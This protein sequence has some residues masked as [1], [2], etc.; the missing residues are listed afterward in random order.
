MTSHSVRASV[1]KGMTIIK[2]AF[3]WVLFGSV[4]AALTFGPALLRIVALGPIS[5]ASVLAS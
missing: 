1:R 2:L 5:L 4:A 3:A